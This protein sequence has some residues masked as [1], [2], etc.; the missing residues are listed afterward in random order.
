MSDN[1]RRRTFLVDS[2]VRLLDAGRTLVGGSPLKVLRFAAPI[3]LSGNLAATTRDRL[4]DNGMIHPTYPAA[5]VAPRDV[6]VVI[7]CFNDADAL[8]A[9]LR[10]LAE[11]LPDSE[12]TWS[13]IVVDDASQDPTSIEDA[14]A[15][16]A[17][18]APHLV[19]R[20]HN[21][22]PGAARNTGLNHVTTPYVAFIDAGCVPEPGWLAVLMAHFQDARIALVAPRVTADPD[23]HVPTN[24]ADGGRIVRWVAARIGR[25][26]R[27]R[28]SLDLGSAPA[29]VAPRTRVAYVPSACIVA[30]TATLRA[31]DGFDETLRVGED[32]DLVWQLAERW[33]VRYEPSA[34]VHHD[35]RATPH[36]WLRRR[37]TYGTSAAPLAIRHPG[38]VPP[39][40]MSRWSALAWAC[41]VGGKPKL[42]AGI[43]M[44]STAMLARQMRNIEHPMQLAARYA[45]LGNIYAGRLL[46]EALRRPW[47]PLAFVAIAW[48]RPAL[49]RGVIAALVVPPLLEWRPA[50]ELDPASWLV[51]RIADD[52]AYGTGVIAGCV[53]ERTLDPLVPALTS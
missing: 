45:G 21:G 27:A 19:R 52:M 11:S 35:V 39:L 36:A 49:R 22:G 32:V 42:G 53:T 10:G 37:F 48:G 9:T 34:Q 46:A 43:A 24:E 50:H 13:V 5:H 2:T 16:E 23:R 12:R 3:D 15:E 40:A 29:R 38:T 18:L 47:W 20:T 4:L 30:P 25:Y 33:R 6:S 8:R 51:L 31:V 1:A 26:E 7:P 44:A 17:A 14:V 28:S 41:A